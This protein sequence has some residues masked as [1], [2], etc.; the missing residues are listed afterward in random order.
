MIDGI[1]MGLALRVWDWGS[2]IEIYHCGI[3]KPL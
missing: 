3:G 2:S 1:W